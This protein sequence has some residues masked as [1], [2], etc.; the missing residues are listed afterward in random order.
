MSSPRFSTS[1]EGGVQ[2]PAVQTLAQ[3]GW[4]YI[5]RAEGEAQRGAGWNR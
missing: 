5:S 2:L 1:E 3:L 4:R